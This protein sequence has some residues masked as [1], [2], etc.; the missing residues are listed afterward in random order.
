[1][2]ERA[3]GFSNHELSIEKTVDLGNPA[4]TKTDYSLSDSCSEEFVLRPEMIHQKTEETAVINDPLVLEVETSK[5]S[6]EQE[7]DRLAL[8]NYFQTEKFFYAKLSSEDKDSARANLVLYPNPKILIEKRRRE[9]ETDPE[10][11][12]RLIFDLIG[13]AEQYTELYNLINKELPNLANW[14]PGFAVRREWPN[15]HSH[16]FVKKVDEVLH[17]KSQLIF[18][19]LA[20]LSDCAYQINEAINF[21]EKTE[22]PVERQIEEYLIQNETE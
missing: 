10:L 13:L 9:N 6:P 12:K 11:A 5:L 16:E 15:K 1:M 17:V 21:L 7:K 8:E 3:N 14:L 4:P 22:R 18:S 2:P 19:R 20:F